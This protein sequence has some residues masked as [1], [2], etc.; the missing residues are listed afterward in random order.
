VPARLAHRATQLRGIG[1][2]R[3]G[4][5]WWYELVTAHPGVSVVP[6]TRCD[7]WTFGDSAKLVRKDS[8]WKIREVD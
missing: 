6:G 5:S 1:A 4:S 7:I 3:S 2:Q 8:F